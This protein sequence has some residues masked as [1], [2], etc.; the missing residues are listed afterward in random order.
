MN[1]I[2]HNSK[3]TLLEFL[4][5]GQCQQMILLVLEVCLQAI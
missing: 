4:N 2:E 5:C 3:G 1:F